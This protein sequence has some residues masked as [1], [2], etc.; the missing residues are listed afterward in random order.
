MSGFLQLSLQVGF[1]GHVLS[2]CVYFSL[3]TETV[4]TGFRVMQHCLCI[5]H[6]INLYHDIG[7]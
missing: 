4:Y 7:S 2:Q 1:N 6:S 5:S 3:F